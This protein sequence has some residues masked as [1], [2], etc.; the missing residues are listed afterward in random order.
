MSEASLHWGGG[1]V[2]KK[3]NI[4]MHGCMWYTLFFF[5]FPTVCSFTG[6]YSEDFIDATGYSRLGVFRTST[7]ETPDSEMFVNEEYSGSI[8]SKMR[9]ENWTLRDLCQGKTAGVLF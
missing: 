7:M 2:D 9:K 1:G 8:D 5:F 6:D 4:A 3:L